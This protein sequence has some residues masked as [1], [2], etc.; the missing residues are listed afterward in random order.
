ME[1]ELPDLDENVA[2][3]V[4][5]GASVGPMTMRA[6]VDGVVAGDRSA[7]SLV[8][9]AG[10]TDWVR[11]DA[12]SE[13]RRLGSL[14]AP[15]D[16]PSRWAL[17]E[18][19]PNTA[20]PVDDA[21]DAAGTRSEPE[22]APGPEVEAAD[23]APVADEASSSEP[24][25]VEVGF[26]D[27]EPV[28]APVTNAGT[29][30]NES[31]SEA[32][33]ANEPAAATQADSTF[34]RNLPERESASGAQPLERPALTGLFSSG[35]RAE[36]KPDEPV[37]GQ[38]PSP[39]ALDAILAARQSLESVG[40]RIEALSSATRRSM[41]P[42]ERQPESSKVSGASEGQWTD[43]PDAAAVAVAEAASH[44]EP[45]E[46]AG[47]WTSVD[48]DAQAT[49]VP[50]TQESEPS[51]VVAGRA[52]LT[53]RFDEMV[54]KS[55]AHQRRIEWIMRVD[56]LLLSSCITSIADC[57]FTAIDLNSHE[58]YHRVLFDHN[59][60]ARRVRL[61][62]SPVDMVSEQFGR[63]VRFGLSWGQDVADPDRA[64]ELVR[65]QSTDAEVPPGVVT[66]EADLS[67]SSVSTH[68]E[69]ILAADD[70]VKG[71]YSVD[72]A[73]LDGAIAATL[74]ALESHWNEL[75]R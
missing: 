2:F 48:G 14:E 17:L 28:T 35:A 42:E 18:Q 41:S 27:L 3:I 45:G 44:P 58:S 40:A 34:P 47:S 68:V 9:W 61:E 46:R 1:S 75:F 8:W 26:V 62:L 64:F 10:A 29:S 55:T 59:S 19:L 13:L 31:H 43:I 72:R 54:R 67:T 21:V 38:A 73:S 56:E 65:E 51:N 16:A 53:A 23:A 36:P 71:D 15:P 11:F 6:I 60:D 5:N 74:H 32:P 7:T 4:E 24:E 33:A 69:L 39:D 66:C 12:H 49:P 37:D 63:H 50:S 25:Q 52:S 22:A 30:T 70:F 57:G 20:D